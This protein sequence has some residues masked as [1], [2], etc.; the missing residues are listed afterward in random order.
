MISLLVRL[1]DWL[2]TVKFRH[3]NH[4]RRYKLLWR[5]CLPLCWL[6]GRLTDE[7]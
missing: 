6:R 5:A 4:Q 7:R 3:R 2:H 1:D